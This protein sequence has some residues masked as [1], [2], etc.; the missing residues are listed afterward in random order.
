MTS[1][2]A[3]LLNK[4]IKGGIPIMLKCQR[5]DCLHNDKEGKCFAK[6]IAIDG[7]TAQTT[8]G[9]SCSS[10]IPAHDFQNSEFADDFMDIDEVPSGV[11]NIDCAAKN[12]RFN[13][14]RACIAADVKINSEDASCETFQK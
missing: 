10:Y 9:T 3:K 2:I 4:I 13:D 1:K 6:K 11:Q 7:R 8:S 14:N 12:C 5:T